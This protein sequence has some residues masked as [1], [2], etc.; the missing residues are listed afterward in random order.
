VGVPTDVSVVDGI[1]DVVCEVP[2]DEGG[3]TGGRLLVIEVPA[4]GAEG[5]MVPEQPAKSSSRAVTPNKVFKYKSLVVFI[6]PFNKPAGG[7]HECLGRAN[8]DNLLNHEI[9]TVASLPQKD[10]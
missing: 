8:P 9:L 7:G 3:G 4:G 10:K 5:A 6:F 1:V 2:V